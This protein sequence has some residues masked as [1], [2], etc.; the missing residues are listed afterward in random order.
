MRKA[1]RAIVVRGDDFLIMDRN[2]FGRHYY[3]LIGG[4]VAPGETL[5]QALNKEV[6]E[7]TG[8]KIANPRLVYEEN[9]GDPYGMQYV[10][11]CDYISGEPQLSAHAIETLVNQLG[12]NTYKPLWV[13]KHELAK[14]PFRSDVLKQEIIEAL[15]KGFP[16]TPKQLTSQA[17][18]K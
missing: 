11:L 10:F 3:T 12:Q 9:A 2:K 14:Y 5:E 7:E 13:K 15:E 6:S 16:Q 17:D 4:G 18:I 8:I 1:V